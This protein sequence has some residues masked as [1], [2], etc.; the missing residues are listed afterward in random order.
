MPRNGRRNEDGPTYTMLNPSDR[1]GENSALSD[2]STDRLKV[3]CTRHGLSSSGT[4]ESMIK[5]IR[6]Y[7]SMEWGGDPVKGQS[8]QTS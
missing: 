8:S 4:R 5:D 2:L 6:F 1:W 7:L 3:I